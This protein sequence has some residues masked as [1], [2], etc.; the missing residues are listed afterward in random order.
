MDRIQ[1]INTQRILWCL[2]DFGIAVEALADQ[3]GLKADTLKDFL[4][5][6]GHPLTYLQLKKVA[7]YFGR[8]VLFFLE[9][10]PVEADNVHSVQF[11][12]LTNTRPE[13][14]PELRKL[15]ERSERQREI[16]LALLEELELDPPRLNFPDLPKN[17]IKLAAS[18]VR[19]WLG[20]SEQI[21]FDTIRQAIENQGIL[22][23][24]SNGYQ[25]PWQ[26]DKRSPVSGFSLWQE[27]CPVIVVK[28]QDAETRQSF[29]LI[30]E[31][32]HLLLHKT[33]RIDDENDFLTET[34]PEREANAFAGHFLV[35]DRYLLQIDMH[36]KPGNVNGFEAWLRQHSAYWCVSTEVILRRLADT[37]RISSEEYNNWRIWYKAQNRTAETVGRRLYRHREPRH[38]FGDPFVKT[39][40]DAHSAGVL[41]LNKACQYLD[42]LKITDL[43]RLEGFYAAH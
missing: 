8:G 33:G 29:T 11:R 13:L 7:D 40:L 21:S 1:N 16:Y 20:L 15:I 12:T 3:T 27:I 14:D 25:G 2:T 43:H 6:K 34:G 32:G 5:G 31:L 35:P 24:R 38:I 37:G 19:E 17:D 26:I 4:A 36:Q 39:V 28:K 10:E 41:T 23:F 9:Q 42:N 18:R 22:V 30:H